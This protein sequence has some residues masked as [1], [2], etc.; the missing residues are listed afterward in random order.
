[1]IKITKNKL[2]IIMI[3]IF[4]HQLIYHILHIYIYIYIFILPILIIN[5]H[6][7]LQN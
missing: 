7:Q 6:Q 5:V 1:M 4:L 2:N 3:I